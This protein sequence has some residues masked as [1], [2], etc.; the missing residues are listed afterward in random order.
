MSN[1]IHRLGVGLFSAL[2]VLAFAAPSAAKIVEFDS[3]IKAGLGDGG[4]PPTTTSI[5]PN[6]LPL[7]S[8]G[9]ITHLNNSAVG[10]GFV[11]VS[12]GAAPQSIMEVRP[13]KYGSPGPLGPS[14]TFSMMGMAGD[15][16][17][18][19]VF[20]STCM[21]A[22]P[23]ALLPAIL[24]ARTQSSSA[25]WPAENTFFIGSKMTVMGGLA[26]RHQVGTGQENHLLAAGN[27]PGNFSVSVNSTF[28]QFISGVAG[29]NTFGG[30]F[31]AT[32]GGRV[33][34]NVN[35]APG[36]TA[37][38]YWLSGP[39]VLG[40]NR[41]GTSAAPTVSQRQTQVVTQSGTFTTNVASGMI[42]VL[43]KV[44]NMP[45]TTGAVHAEDHGGQFVTIR[46]RTGTD[47]RTS[48]GEMGTLLLVT[49]WTANL[50][51]LNLY[52]GGT[53]E[54][55]FTFLPEPGP[56]ALFAAGVLGI[57]ALHFAIR[58]RK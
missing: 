25:A 11:E 21:L 45:Y 42:P 46:D 33:N 41:T 12:S 39:R 32:G 23:P 56:T 19:E 38:G 47:A 54:L 53:G 44:W 52:F 49:P 7:C 18:A 29:G 27:G 43:L 15:N 14:P 30:G 40:H 51:A 37:N 50:Q 5:Q 20:S 57:F 31:R 3:L 58:R 4:N 13:F 34:L 2:V 6:G 28:T 35:L 16:G 36:V 24:N 48:M 26:L 17:G 8:K 9:L 22:F 10:H 55:R 1:A